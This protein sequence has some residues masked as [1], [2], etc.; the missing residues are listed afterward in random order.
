MKKILITGALGHI[1][2]HFIHQL[3]QG[4]YEKVVLLDNLATQRY[5][6]LFNLPSGIPYKF[7]SEDVCTADL[8]ELFASMDAVI[9]LAA[10]TD[11]ANSFDNQEK[12][13]EVN[14]HGTCR[15]ARACAAVGA[16]MV[17]LSTT[18]VYGVQQEVVDEDCPEENLK[19]QSPYADSKL[20]SEHFL[21][22][23]GQQEGLQFIICRFGTIFGTSIG[24]RFHTAVNKFIWQAVLGQP[25]TVWRTALDQKRPYLDL[26]D[27]VRA[28]DFIIKTDCFDN[29][30]YNV[31][32]ANATVRE[33]VELIAAHIPDLHIEYVDAR[34][35][36][37]LSYTVDNSKFQK[38][39][40][41]F[42]GSLDRGIS[43]TIQ[44]LNPLKNR[45]T[46]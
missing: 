2:S 23:L 31:L 44:L 26:N 24:M 1:G 11:A 41:R 10:I 27:A 13:E 19:P 29:Q 20:R 6:S 7:L 40:F 30:I 9:H 17:L 46:A 36:N 37:Q 14:F 5:C 42:L 35:M 16:K 4:D 33:I 39:G 43:D 21:Q 28:L 32:T 12:V 3:T 18:S 38:L 8:E 45:G 15:V 34:I 22:E 25:L